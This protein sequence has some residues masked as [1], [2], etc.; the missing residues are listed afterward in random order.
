M[1][2][3]VW[4]PWTLWGVELPLG[5]RIRIW[6]HAL[7]IRSWSG[8]ECAAWVVTQRVSA[9][10]LLPITSPLK[11]RV[12]KIVCVAIWHFAAQNE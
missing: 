2:K 12:A 11:F 10:K 1:F 9:I 7:D 3:G 4:S 6:V 5:I 8:A